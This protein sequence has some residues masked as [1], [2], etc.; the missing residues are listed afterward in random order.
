MSQK[1]LACT[2][3]F[4]TLLICRLISTTDVT[5]S[6]DTTDTQEKDLLIPSP[7]L[8]AV[9]FHCPDFFPQKTL[10]QLPYTNFSSKLVF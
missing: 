9:F 7:E 3:G 10:G 1:L 4:V 6:K 2:L 5:G 8:N